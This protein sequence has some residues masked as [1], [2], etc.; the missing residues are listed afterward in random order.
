MMIRIKGSDGQMVMD[1]KTEQ[2]YSE[3]VCDEKRRDRYV[4]VDGDAIVEDIA[5]IGGGSSNVGERLTALED[6][7]TAAKIL[8]GVDA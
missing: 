4:V 1:T 8:L 5:P 6:E 3:V 2:L 7:L